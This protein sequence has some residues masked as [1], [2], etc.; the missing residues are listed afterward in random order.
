M[1]KQQLTKQ[2]RARAR[3]M[4]RTS[5]QLGLDHLHLEHDRARQEAIARYTDSFRVLTGYDPSRG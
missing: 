2:Q 4:L 1:A 3:R 5:Y